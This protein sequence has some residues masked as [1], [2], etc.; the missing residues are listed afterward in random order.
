MKKLLITLAAGLFAVSAFADD[1]IYTSP[2]GLHVS[3]EQYDY[4]MR[5]GN[6]QLPTGMHRYH[7]WIRVRDGDRW[8]WY[9]NN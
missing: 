5:T 8:Y 9:H 7:G 1:F 3:K 2:F 4:G 6:W